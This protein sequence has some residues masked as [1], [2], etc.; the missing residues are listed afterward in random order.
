M[1]RNIEA[2]IETM[3]EKNMFRVYFELILRFVILIFILLK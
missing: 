1:L 3:Q 2:S